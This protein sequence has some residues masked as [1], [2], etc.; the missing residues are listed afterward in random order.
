MISALNLGQ[1]SD[2]EQRLSLSLYISVC[3]RLCEFLLIEK[4]VVDHQLASIE[5][6]IELALS[7]GC[8]DPMEIGRYHRY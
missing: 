4:Q 2:G 7:S 8:F 5:T 3:I 1:Y 6:L